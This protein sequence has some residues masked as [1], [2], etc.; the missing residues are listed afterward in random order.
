M[1]HT[2]F[3]KSFVFNLFRFK[4]PHYT[5]QMTDGGCPLHFI[6]RLVQG[7]AKICTT[8]GTLYLQAGDV[9]YIP[10]GLRYRSYWTPMVEEVVFYSFGFT[11][12]PCEA[13]M[14]FA[15]QR[16]TCS[17]T[18]KSLLAELEQSPAVSPLSIGRLYRFLGEVYPKLAPASIARHTAL[19]SKATDYMQQHPDAKMAE[20]AQHCGISESG[21]FVKFRTQLGCTPVEMRHTILVDKAKELLETTD[22]TVEEISNALL[23]SSSSYFRKVFGAKTGLTPT[24]YR[25]QT[26]RI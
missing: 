10:M 12:F 23:F 18:E 14:S 8:N 7:K 20:V 3:Y 9:F 15:L 21:L 25:K 4:Q 6:A 5:D 17:A 19:V 13:D 26:R 11:C 16:I 22:L 24:Q 2:K 1:I